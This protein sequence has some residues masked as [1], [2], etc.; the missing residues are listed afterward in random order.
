[1]PPTGLD[2][3]F[4][5]GGKLLL[6]HGWN[7]GLIPAKNSLLFYTMLYHD[8]PQQQAQDQLR[9]YIVPGMEHCSGGEGVSQFDTLGTIDR[10]ATTGVA[11]YRIEATRP[12]VVA[13]F[14]GAP[15]GTA[16][17]AAVASA[18]SLSTL[19]GIQRRGRHRAGEQLHLQASRANR[20]PDQ[21]A[22]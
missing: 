10:W 18:V 17:R 12:T 14:P 6:S 3:Y 19:R 2:A 5:R 13:G 22:P 16:A 8:L 21:P 1:M 20:A 11:P 4:A 7:D 9:F 15:S